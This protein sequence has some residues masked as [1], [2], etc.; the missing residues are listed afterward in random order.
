[1]GAQHVISADIEDSVDAV[2]Q[3][4]GGLGADLIIDTTGAATA[5]KA[6]INM[7]RPGGRILAFSVSHKFLKDFSAFSLYYKEINIIGS[8]ALTAAD[9]Q[10]SIDLVSSGKIKVSELITRKYPL[11]KTA[12]AFEEYEQNPDQILRILI[13]SRI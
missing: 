4:T 7:L 9:M 10:P 6:G 11:N 12:E 8:R 3:L 13:D 1:M 2:I 5:L